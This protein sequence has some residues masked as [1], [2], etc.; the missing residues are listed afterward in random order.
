MSAPDRRFDL[1]GVGSM[2]VDVLHR[3]PRLVEPDEKLLIEPLGGDNAVQ[4]RV[5]GVVL[6]HLAWARVLG[7]R[8]AIFGKQADDEHGRFLRSG[9]ARLGIEPHLDLDGSRSSFAEVYV[10]PDGE[11]AIYMVRGATGEL[12]A[13][14]IESRH[15]PWIEAARWVSTEISQLPLASVRRTL[16]LAREAGARTALDLDVSLEEAIPA[17]GSEA[18]LRAALGL[19]GLIKASPRTLRGLMS[20]AGDP[21]NAARELL[22]RFGAET[23]ALTL[24]DEGAII[25]AEA[26]ALRVPGLE[27]RSRDATGAGDAFLGALIAALDAGLDLRSA[28]LLANAAGAACCE[29]IGA[30]PEDPEASRARVLELYEGTG[31]APYVPRPSAPRADALE[32]FLEVAARETG[33]VCDEL[34]RAAVR[35][36]ARMIREAE[37]RGGRVHVTG[38]GKP[39]H[40]ARYAAALLSSTGTPAT[41]LHGTESTHGSV[42]QMR[43][44]DLLIAIS[45]SGETEELLECVGL[46]RHFGARVVAVTREP[47]SSLGRSADL[48]LRVGVEDEGGPNGLA[49]RTSVLAELIALAAL[50][51][52]LEATHGFDREDFR[53][54]HP[55][56]TLGRPD[57]DSGGPTSSP[58]A[59]A[60]SSRRG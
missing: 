30:F 50:S 36:A 3:V 54:R 60:R 31:G 25:C 7:M 1:V 13:D 18:D 4:H 45:N 46:V 27:V 11:R 52:E 2:V 29:Q 19:A 15:R 32:G 44:E 40:V 12:G 51:V 33:R 43:P 26:K 17:L 56:G 57:G 16:E 41:F 21:E 14:E 53:R 24:G 38:V 10:T 28:T 6:N 48:V 9:M 5:G 47:R 49:P 34:D 22:Q 37:G 20:G 58:D 42:G 23:V 39:E 8:V 59:P 55:A 35:R